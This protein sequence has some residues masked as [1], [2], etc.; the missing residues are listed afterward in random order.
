MVT[1]ESTPEMAAKVYQMMERNL[2]VVRQRL[3]RALTLADKVL[4]VNL[5]SEPVP[6]GRGDRIGQLLIAPVTR[7]SF[8]ES[9]DLSDSARGEGGFGSTGV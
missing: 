9:E 2:A 5:G 3:G 1:I 7:A 6:I 4:L 8:V